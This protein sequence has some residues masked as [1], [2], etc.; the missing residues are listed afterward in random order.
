MKRV[1]GWQPLQPF[2]DRVS[3]KKALKYTNGSAPSTS[4]AS[5]LQH[6]FPLPISSS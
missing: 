3:P 2:E 1:E 5:L 6:L 4:Q